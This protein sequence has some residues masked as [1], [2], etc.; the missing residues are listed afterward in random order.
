M[1]IQTG[2]S[3]PLKE[4]DRALMDTMLFHLV[5]FY[6]IFIFTIDFLVIGTEASAAVRSVPSKETR[7]A[8]AA[9]MQSNQC[10]AGHKDATS[11]KTIAPKS[12]DKKSSIFNEVC[13]FVNWVQGLSSP[14]QENLLLLNKLRRQYPEMISNCPRFAIE[15]D[16]AFRNPDSRAIFYENTGG[17]DGNSK[18][19]MM[20]LPVIKPKAERKLGHTIVSEEIQVP[21]Q[22]IAP[23][24]TVIK[25][26]IPEEDKLLAKESTEPAIA[27]SSNEQ[28]EA[29][30]VTK[31]VRKDLQQVKA[32]KQPVTVTKILEK[33]PE[34]TIKA[35]DPSVIAPPNP[36]VVAQPVERSL[37]PETPPE[38]LLAQVKTAISPESV[39]KEASTCDIGCTLNMFELMKTGNNK[40]IEEY[41]RHTDIQIAELRELIKTAILLGQERDRGI[42]RR[43]R[44]ADCEEGRKSLKRKNRIKKA[45]LYTSM[46]TSIRKP[47]TVSS[48]RVSSRPASVTRP[49]WST[50]SWTDL[51]SASSCLSGGNCDSLPTDT[52]SLLASE[53]LELQS[54]EYD[55][56]GLD[57]LRSNGDLSSNLFGSWNIFSKK[58]SRNE[59]RHEDKREIEAKL[60]N[61]SHLLNKLD[62][63]ILRNKR[64]EEEIESVRNAIREVR[65]EYE[66]SSN[67]GSKE[68]DS[69]K[70]P[71]TVTTT[72]VYIE[73]SSS[74]R[75]KT[76]D[77]PTVS[78]INILHLEDV[79][80]PKNTA[81]QAVQRVE[82]SIS[83]PKPAIPPV[84]APS[85]VQERAGQRN[86]GIDQNGTATTSNDSSK[87]CDK[88]KE[89][90]AEKSMTAEKKPRKK[91]K[92]AEIN[93]EDK[94]GGKKRLINITL[95]LEEFDE[96]V[97]R[98]ALLSEL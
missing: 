98:M 6:F 11:C 19:E 59:A 93:L 28:V 16:G 21:K 57:S 33:E 81:P 88:T 83:A 96:L 67:D 7:I 37:L 82:S 30:T 89:T 53:S 10:I 42:I 24:K 1:V 47:G 84:P 95:P 94:R 34:T 91:L 92:S 73:G 8:G 72:T 15:N 17:N 61:L 76:E 87:E 9:Q 78:T 90:N 40:M 66:G 23:V 45:L 55:G 31:L 2:K 4:R 36:Q 86:K 74:V 70:E 51:P 26:T 35:V 18:V 32:A 68:T 63:Y 12:T 79:E 22:T 29:K 20:M 27:D 5:K 38:E 43:T 77:Y 13:I 46:P 41:R 39:S 14:S 3:G 65:Q 62:T 71:K 56:D 44:N 48:S 50:R 97:N 85:Q 75:K 69:G 64:T 25:K 49:S 80:D 58:R 60:P 54:D 52:Q